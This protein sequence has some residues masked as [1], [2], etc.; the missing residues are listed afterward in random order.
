LDRQ[1]PRDLF[2]VKF[3]LDNEGFTEDL[4]K[5]FLVFLISHQR[6]MSEL[7]APHRKDIRDIYDAEFADMAAINIPVEELEQTREH[8]I[9]IIHQNMTDD[10]RN[11]SLSFKDRNPNWHLLGLENIADIAHL[12]SV[13]WKLMNLKNMD[14]IKHIK[15]LDKLKIVLYPDKENKTAI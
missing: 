3:L 13:Q 12:P 4:R 6:P 7:L 8:L 15:A 1:H 9:D 10:E 14:S 5:T 2:D 11:F